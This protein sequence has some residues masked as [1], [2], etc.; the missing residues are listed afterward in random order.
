MATQQW[1]AIGKL[2]E[3]TGNL[4]YNDLNGLKTNKHELK[5]FFLIVAFYK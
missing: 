5:Y 4:I 2:V 3:N 1:S